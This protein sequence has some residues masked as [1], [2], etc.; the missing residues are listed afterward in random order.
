MLKATEV[1]KW[2]YNDDLQV[3][4]PSK[5]FDT[6]SLDVFSNFE[7]LHEPAPGRK[8]FDISKYT[9]T[10]AGAYVSS[11]DRARGFD[12]EKALVTKLRLLG[13]ECYELAH[14][15]YNYIKHIDLEVQCANGLVVHI[16]VE[17]P[18]ALRKASAA[19]SAAKDILSRPQDKFVCLQLGHQST[20]YGGCADYMAFGLTNGTFL[21]SERQ[22]LITC[23]EL[24]MADFTN[25]TKKYRSAWPETALWVPYVRTF[26]EKSI[27]MTYMDLEDLPI[28]YWCK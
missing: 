8:L 2:P 4:D 15:T 11:A 20:L 5:A 19:S 12:A 26:N 22:Q 28:K 10:S 16:D 6:S 13:H 27:V 17:A 9:E 21:I 18:K 25:G 24:K 7:G 1:L 23:I 14:F 3:M